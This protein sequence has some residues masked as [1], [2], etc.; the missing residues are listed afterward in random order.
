MT[1]SMTLF[2]TVERPA[3]KAGLFAFA[4]ADADCQSALNSL[5]WKRMT[6]FSRSLGIALALTA[7]V[8]CA[9]ARSGPSVAA[10]GDAS[11][12]DKSLVL[13]EEPGSGAAAKLLSQGVTVVAEFG[14]DLL[15]FAR[16]D[17]L[18]RIESGG[19]AYRLLDPRTAG[20]S[21]F[22]VSLREGPGDETALPQVRVLARAGLEALLEISAKDAWEL[23]ARGFEIAA[24][25]PTAMRVNPPDDPILPPLPLQADPVIEEIVAE[26]SIARI[27]ERV[28][29][30]QDF[31]SRYSLH[32]S[33]LAAAEWIKTRFESFGIDSVFF[34]VW[35]ADYAPNVV[36]VLP[37]VAR[38][39]RVIVIGGHYDSITSNVNFCP[40]ADDNASGTACVLECAEVL[41]GHSFDC[42]IV[43]IAFSGEEQGLLG[44]EAYASEAAARGENVI[45]MIAVDM[46]G[47]VAPQDLVD[48]DI[49]RN[50]TS[51]WLRDR[52]MGVAETYVPGFSLVDG[53][54]TGGTSD[55]AS[56]WRH[57]YDALLFIEDSASRSPYIHTAND[58]VGV[59][60]INQTLAEGSVK[61]AAALVADLANPFRVAIAHTPLADTEDETHPYR[62]AAKIFSD[63]PLD[64]GSLVVRYRTGGDWSTLPLSPTGNPDEYEAYIPAQTGGT[65]VSYYIS[66]SD[67]NGIV[68]RDPEG[69]PPEPYIFAVGTLAVVFDDDF[70]TDK[71]WTPGAPDDNATGGIWERADPNATMA[72]TMMIQP[73]DDHTAAPGV[74]CFVTGNSNPGA[75]QATND[76]D[77]G[78]TTLLSPVLDL[79]SCPNAWV[80]YYRWYTNNTGGAP[81]TD[82]WAVDASADG[83]STWVRLES[84]HVT[85]RQ[86]SFVEHHLDR[87][88][89]LTSQV[90]FRFVASD[91]G[92]GSIVEAA[93]DDFR[94][95]TYRSA[96]TA[97]RDDSDRPPRTLELSQNHPNPFNPSTT[98]RFAVPAPGSR[99][100]LRVYDVTGRLVATLVDNEKISG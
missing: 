95:V 50:E 24:V 51:I 39:D 2:T 99:V 6:R 56:F 28:Q 55:H 76:V 47:Y 34:H 96:L 98:I 16:V 87:F 40:G 14:K 64:P 35:N 62:V 4:G 60:Y 9:P 72:G 81:D 80:S 82:T 53:Y 91:E 97:I 100:S 7:A 61:T 74:F 92:Q 20:K 23:S 5:Y 54:L 63:A 37:G 41:G 75:S 8:F 71:G 38:P 43:F 93:L 22:T 84:T 78:K 30:L 67:V 52:V 48:L 21:Y 42:T 59:S 46:I 68:A 26:V 18:R 73:E 44:S 77:D 12:E 11:A 31:A 17:D 29:R 69:A 70:E 65:V 58:L 83:G 45:A 36:A 19:F 1:D 94:I 88:I 57:G 10:P 15:A 49:I 79:S 66:A 13:I 25:F 86:W 32:D 90:R 85:A 33:S 3:S 89:S 27:G